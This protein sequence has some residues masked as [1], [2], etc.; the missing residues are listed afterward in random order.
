M[1]LKAAGMDPWEY[2]DLLFEEGEERSEIG[3]GGGIVTFLPNGEINISDF[4][5]AS[6]E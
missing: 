4:G 3:E 1:Q 6:E 5:S 2:L